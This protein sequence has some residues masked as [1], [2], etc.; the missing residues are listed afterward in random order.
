MF[1]L[2]HSLNISGTHNFVS[3]Y[4]ENTVNIITLLDWF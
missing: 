1:I 3:D 4:F 2:Q